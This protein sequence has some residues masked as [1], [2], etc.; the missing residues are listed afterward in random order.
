M[1]H[2][3]MIRCE[4]RTLYKVEGVYERRWKEVAVTEIIQDSPQDIRCAHCHGAVRVRRQKAAQGPE[5]HVEHRS[6][7]DSEGCRGGHYFQGEH[8]MSPKPIS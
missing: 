7:Q 2:D 8:R 4:Q 1:A 5:D 3:F 6:R